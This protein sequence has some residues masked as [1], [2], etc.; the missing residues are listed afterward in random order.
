MVRAHVADA[1][2]PAPRDSAAWCRLRDVQGCAVIVVSGDI[3]TCTAPRLRDAVVVAR[4][5]SDRIVIDLAQVRLID[6]SGLRAIVAA[7]QPCGQGRP[8]VCLV[9]PSR[10]VRRTLVVAGLA[11]DF[12]IYASVDEAVDR[13]AN[14]RAAR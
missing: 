4:E 9:G 13:M 3:D 1:N 8:V 5:Y 14:G 6:S 7:H 2:V 12:S 10:F 11:R